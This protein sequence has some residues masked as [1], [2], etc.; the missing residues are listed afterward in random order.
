VRRRVAT[1][2]ASIGAAS[3]LA[4]AGAPSTTSGQRTL[5]DAAAS[6]VHF[7]AAGDYSTGS[8]V[9]AVLATVHTLAPD[10]HLALGDL[11][12][13]AAGS[14]QAWCDVV[15]GAVGAG[16]P[17]ELISGNHE[18]DGVNGNIND[19]SA[20]LP[21]QLPGAVGTYGRQWYVDVPA[22][23]PLVRFVFISP[24]LTYPDGAWA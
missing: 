2:V 21:N 3:A 13:G 1:L 19:F 6:E 17:F 8:R 22:A 18:S 15:T 11:S 5:A 20:C 7:T 24:G 4:L 12:Y 9:A 14:E 16:F 23:S 10:L